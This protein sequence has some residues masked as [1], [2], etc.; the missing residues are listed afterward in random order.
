MWGTDYTPPA[1]RPHQTRRRR[2]DARTDSSVRHDG[3]P[4]LRTTVRL[5]V[6]NPARAADAPG[7]GWRG[8]TR[9]RARRPVRPRRVW[10]RRSQRGRGGCSGRSASGPRRAGPYGR[11][12]QRLADRSR[13]RATTAPDTATGPRGR[14]S[15]WVA[16]WSRT[17]S[18][19]SLSATRTAGRSTVPTV[20]S[21][22]SSETRSRP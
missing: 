18:T 14:S 9:H 10:R 19:R 8:P 20:T 1:Q 12:S 2:D 17:P 5:L 7:H 16:T 11:D 6:G 22:T 15:R 3:R 13:P 4:V 21:C